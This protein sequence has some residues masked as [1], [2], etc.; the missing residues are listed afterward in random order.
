MKID[1]KKYLKDRSVCKKTITIKIEEK[2]K[3]NNQK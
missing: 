2:T 1:F 3:I